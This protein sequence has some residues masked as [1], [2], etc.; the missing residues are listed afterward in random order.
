MISAVT[1]LRPDEPSPCNPCIGQGI[2]PIMLPKLFVL[3]LFHVFS[4]GKRG[5]GNSAAAH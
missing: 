4:E 1:A 2:Y 5:S 3:C